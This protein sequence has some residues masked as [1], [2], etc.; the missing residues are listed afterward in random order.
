[1]DQPRTPKAESRTDVYQQAYA[2]VLN[3]PYWYSDH[4]QLLDERFNAENTR[5]RS[6]I[7]IDILNRAA[8]RRTERRLSQEYSNL[9]LIHI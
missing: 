7:L 1:M 2:A 8:R 3:N 6:D 9:S 4:P 5:R